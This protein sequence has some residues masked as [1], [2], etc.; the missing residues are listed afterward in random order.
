MR[1][2]LICA[3][4]VMLPLA[5]TG[6][7]NREDSGTAIGAIAGGVLGSQVGRG[8]GSIATAAIGAVV[9]GVIGSEIGRSMDQRDRMLAQRAEFAA[10]E[11]GTSGRA[12]IWRNPDNDR[13]GEVIPGPPMRRGSEDCRE[14]EHRVYIDG[15]PRVMRGIACR[16]PDGTWR[17][18]EP[19]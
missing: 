2:K 10:L 19:A 5:S 16:N 9:G 3:F 8:R 11:R 15:R 18:V 14:Y 4:L 12:E 17:N 6:C 13:H 7:A 1:L